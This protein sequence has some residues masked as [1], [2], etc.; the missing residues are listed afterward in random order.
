MLCNHLL[1]KDHEIRK[2]PNGYFEQIFQRGTRSLRLQSR[3]GAESQ[4]QKLWMLRG[5]AKVGKKKVCGHFQ[6]V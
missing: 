3:G 2:S 6:A 5:K 1:V 4:Q